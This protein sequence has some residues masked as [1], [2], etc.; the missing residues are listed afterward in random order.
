MKDYHKDQLN[1]AV[2]QLTRDAFDA[3]FN[4]SMYGGNWRHHM[5]QSQ[6]DLWQLIERII[7]AEAK[8]SAK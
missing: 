4:S 1:K 3:G 8:T 2:G 6:K 5:E 7:A